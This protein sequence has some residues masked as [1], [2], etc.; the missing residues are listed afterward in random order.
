MTEQLK[1]AN[2]LVMFILWCRISCGTESVVGPNRPQLHYLDSTKNLQ[3][4]GLI[5]V[6]IEQHILLHIL[7]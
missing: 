6:H 3:R 5:F 7:S 2:N 4:W 1:H